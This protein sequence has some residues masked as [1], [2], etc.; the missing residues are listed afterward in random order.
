M[1]MQQQQKM[2]L[3]L[4]PKPIGCNLRAWKVSSIG[5]RKLQTSVKDTVSC[6]FIYLV[7]YTKCFS[8]NTAWI[9][10]SSSTALNYPPLHLKLPTTHKA[11]SLCILLAHV[12]I[13]VPTVCIALIFSWQANPSLIETK[14]YCPGWQSLRDPSSLLLPPYAFMALSSFIIWVFLSL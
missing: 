7:K 2:L 1:Q 5:V 12:Q 10:A 13:S 4:W 8:P 14:L 3:F 6:N 9:E 11:P